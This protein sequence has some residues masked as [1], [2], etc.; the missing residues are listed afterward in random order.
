MNKHLWVLCRFVSTI[1]VF[2]AGIMVGIYLAIRGLLVWVEYDL[3][4]NSFFLL[5]EGVYLAGAAF[6]FFVSWLLYAVT[7]YTVR[8][9]E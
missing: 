4:I 1:F 2:G 9:G 7:V 5:P 8:S 3:A 6:L